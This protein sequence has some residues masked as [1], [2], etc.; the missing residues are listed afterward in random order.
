MELL[1]K[2][3]RFFD[4]RLENP[5]SSARFGRALSELVSMLFAVVFGVG[6]GELGNMKWGVDAWVLIAAYAAIV[7]SW[8]GYNYGVTKGPR[9]DN[10]ILFGIDILI[11]VAYWLLI[12]R[13]HHLDEAPIV[14]AVV[15][16]L[17]ALWE[18][19]RYI[20]TRWSPARRAAWFN[21][22]FALVPAALAALAWE[23]KVL[24]WVLPLVVITILVVVYRVLIVF[25]IYRQR[26]SP[27]REIGAAA[28]DDQ[29]L[30][31]L[32]ENA[33]GNAHAP[34]SKYMVGAC[35]R[36]ASG[37]TYGGC[38]VEF[39]NYSNTI[40]A[41]EGAIAQAIAA[42]EKRIVAVAVVTQGDE[43]AWPCG[44]CLQSLY[45]LGGANL[46]VIA[47]NGKT[48]EVKLMR[49]LL[50]HGFSLKLEDD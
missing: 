2:A 1:A 22:A 21:L 37:A 15:F 46:R 27:Q 49:E 43:P 36:A 12:N 8:L 16:V 13:R 5:D 32:A 34:L 17:Y 29:K 48:H 23:P 7:A 11:V 20:R 31:L 9:E 4:V 18:A 10:L 38:N 26:P 3:V 25:W 41:E 28:A 19:V 45:E 39:C 44:M 6:L 33:R 30:I 24:Q 42:G 35:V 50:P 47:G 40:H 14:Y